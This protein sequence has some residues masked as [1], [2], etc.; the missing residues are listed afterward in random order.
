MKRE[1]GL[2]KPVNARTRPARRRHALREADG[3]KNVASGSLPKKTRTAAHTRAIRVGCR[4]DLYARV[5]AKP[6]KRAASH[7]NNF[8]SLTPFRRRSPVNKGMEKGAVCVCVCVTASFPT[9]LLLGNKPT[10]LGTR[11]S[12]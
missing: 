11:S 9:S 4:K 5:S 10:A 3:L 7:L 6:L 2:R 12:G 1:R 8:A